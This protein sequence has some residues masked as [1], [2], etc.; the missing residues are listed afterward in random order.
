MPDR[1]SDF[2]RGEEVFAYV[3]KMTTTDE[4]LKID[5]E[6]KLAA[7]GPCFRDLRTYSLKL[8]KYA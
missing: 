2:L 5:S 3:E 1:P 4:K 6:N 7:A 8:P